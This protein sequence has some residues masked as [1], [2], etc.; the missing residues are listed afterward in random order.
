MYTTDQLNQ[1]FMGI[2]V[3]F[4]EPINHGIFPGN[5]QVFSR[6]STHKIQ[7]SPEDDES[8]IGVLV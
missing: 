8:A 4:Q 2:M 7:K 3:I 1:W 5:Q 6:G